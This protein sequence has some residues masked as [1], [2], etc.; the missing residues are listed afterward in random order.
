MIKILIV[1]DEQ[2]IFDSIKKPFYYIGFTFFN[3]KT[4]R[5]AL[6]VFEKNKPKIIFLDIIMPDVDG[7]DLLKQFKQLDPGVIVIMVTA[8]GDAETQKRAMA[9]GAD[10][11]M[12][13]P[14]SFDDLRVVAIR[15]IEKLLGKSGP[16]QKPHILIVDDEEKARQ[17]LRNFISPRYDC[18][19]FEASDGE[20][21]VTKVK[22]I[23]P[24]IILLDIRMP[25][26]SGME[27][28]N[29]IKQLSPDTRIIVI[30]AWKS[31]DVATK[32]MRA[33]AFDYMDKP[34][35]FKVFQERFESALVSIGR[36]IKKH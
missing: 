19:I 3:A 34:V 36:L 18:E 27:A 17:N 26:I 9:L 11:Y 10:E 30:S 13:K 23:K 1:D 14:F 8:K 25:G 5:K 12:T 7:L 15:K 22:A 16:M 29:E 21:A 33:G 24:D 31:P 2:A 4:A 32:A 6:S 20:S 35:D 28:I